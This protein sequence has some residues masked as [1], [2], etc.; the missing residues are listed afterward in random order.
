MGEDAYF[1]TGSIGGS[2][3]T[4]ERATVII[5]RD[6]KHED[7]LRQAIVEGLVRKEVQQDIEATLTEAA[8]ARRY[9]EHME[10]QAQIAR[11][12][13][14]AARV[15]MGEMDWQLKEAQRTAK[16]Q[17]EQYGVAVRAYEQ[18]KQRKDRNRKRREAAIFLLSVFLFLVAAD[19]LG[20]WIFGLLSR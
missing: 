12:Q 15:R 4:K 5:R 18:A 14:D 8:E 9:A 6:G 3:E 20:R 16:W 2:M 10:A 17:A 19:I 7:R 13:A 1:Q 11:A